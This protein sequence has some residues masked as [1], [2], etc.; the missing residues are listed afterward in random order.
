VV[1]GSI[2]LKAKIPLEMGVEKIVRY[3]AGIAY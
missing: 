3:I 2:P 1:D